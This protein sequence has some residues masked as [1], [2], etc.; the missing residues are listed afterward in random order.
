MTE[1]ERRERHLAKHR[2]YNQ[3]RK[4]KA[5]YA[6]YE[7]KHPERKEN[8]WEPSRNALRSAEGMS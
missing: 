4:G 7:T 1:D 5:R 2:K 6:R 3:S 8:R